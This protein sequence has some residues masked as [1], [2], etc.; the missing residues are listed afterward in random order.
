MYQ[1]QAVRTEASIILLIK[2]FFFQAED[3]IRDSVASLGLGDVYKRQGLTCLF[4]VQVGIFM[5]HMD[6][7]LLLIV[8]IFMFPG[9]LIGMSLRARRRLPVDLFDNTARIAPFMI[10]REAP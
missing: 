6:G 1:T 8:K 10:C 2:Y 4:E 3:G 7:V 9:T 5:E